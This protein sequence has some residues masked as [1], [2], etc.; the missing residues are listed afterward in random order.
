MVRTVDRIAEELAHRIRAGDLPAGSRLPA[1]RTLARSEG[2]ALETASRVYRRLAEMGLIVG[3]RG[4][5]TFVREPPAPLTTSPAT[6]AGAVNLATNEPLAS[7]QGQQ[8]RQALKDLAS[9]GAV[10]A[11]L[12]QEPPGGRDRDRRVVATYLLGRGIDVPPA[13]VL[14][15]NGSQ[16]G[17][18][19]ALDAVAGP[20]STVAIDAVSYPGMRMLAE[21][22]RQQLAAIPASTD[23]GPDLAALERIARSQSIAA[24]YVQPTLHNPLSWVLDADQRHRIVHIARSYDMAIIEDGTYAFLEPGAPPPVQ[25]LAPE[26]TIYVGS[27]SKNLASGLRFGFV[28]MPRGLADAV[29]RGV[30]SSTY[31]SPSLVTALGVRWIADGTVDR[32]EEERRQDAL[33]RQA[34]ARRIL[35]GYDTIT[36]PRSYIVWLPLPPWRGMGS[37]AS[38]LAREGIAVTTADRFAT[39]GRPSHALRL[40]LGTPELP[41]LTEGLRVVRRVLDG[42]M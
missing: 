6:G 3:E 7:G 38:R 32:L 36:H 1:H 17:L 22:R 29:T 31:G 12:R 11:L 30:R 2:V 21:A 41:D 14:L 9:S 35:V 39:D 33:R 10:E 26:R 13:S 8:L 16:Q 37:V 27:L 25:S 4:R 42:W 20:G 28:V 15:T 24:V 19:A 40:A 34:I 18:S 5:G 23:G